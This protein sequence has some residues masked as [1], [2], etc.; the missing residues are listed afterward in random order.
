MLKKFWYYSRY[1]LINKVEFESGKLCYCRQSEHL[2]VKA[3]TVTLGGRSR[4]A[5]PQLTN[6]E[7]W[8][9]AIHQSQLRRDDRSDRVL[10]IWI[11]NTVALI[12]IS[13]RGRGCPVSA[14]VANRR[15]PSASQTAGRCHLQAWRFHQLLSVAKWGGLKPRYPN[16]YIP[17]CAFS[18]RFV[19]D[20][21]T[22]ALVQSYH[23]SF[24]RYRV[25]FKLDSISKGPCNFLIFI[26]KKIF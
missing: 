15:W 9:R 22:V 11:N 2:R 14:A 25:F 3:D 24:L 16:F 12:G 21:L 23:F 20:N 13:G 18:T 10:T 26:D 5:I 19:K 17:T 8:I 1:E 4:S 6:N 7:R